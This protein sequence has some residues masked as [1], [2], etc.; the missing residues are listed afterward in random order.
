MVRSSLVQCFE[1]QP[2]LSIYWLR[3]LV[4]R[5]SANHGCTP[6]EMPCVNR[7]PLAVTSVNIWPW[8]P[9]ESLVLSAFFPSSLCTIWQLASLP[10]GPWTRYE[11]LGSCGGNAG[12]KTTNASISGSKNRRV[13]MQKQISPL[14]YMESMRFHCSTGMKLCRQVMRSYVSNAYIV[15]LHYP[16]RHHAGEVQQ[17]FSTRYVSDVSWP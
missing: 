9:V 6:Q 13:V 3:Q 11:R 15:G 7:Y 1:I 2:R 4:A 14:Q 12:N 5:H 8:P 16:S 17:L 10:P